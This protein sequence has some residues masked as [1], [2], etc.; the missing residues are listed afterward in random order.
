MAAHLRAA[1]AGELDEVERVE[2]RDRPRKVRD[3]DEARLQRPDED[4]FAAVVVARDLGAELA[5][6]RRQLAG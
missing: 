2:D 4:R 1:V 5:N 6:A 3:E